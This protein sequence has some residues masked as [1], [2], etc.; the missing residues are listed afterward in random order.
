MSIGTRIQ[1]NLHQRVVLLKVRRVQL[2]GLD[3][4]FDQALPRHRYTEDIEAINVGE[5][6]HLR[7]SHLR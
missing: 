5:V 1:A 7:R 6:L 2:I 4:I 3:V